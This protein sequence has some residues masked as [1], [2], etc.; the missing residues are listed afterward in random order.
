[1]LQQQICIVI[2][3]FTWTEDLKIVFIQAPMAVF[4]S[5]VSEWPVFKS[6]R[7]LAHSSHPDI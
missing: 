3:K 6:F 5:G 4:L 2:V 1:M 7:C